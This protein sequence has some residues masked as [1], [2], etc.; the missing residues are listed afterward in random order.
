MLRL[1]VKSTSILGAHVVLGKGYAEGSGT[2]PTPNH[3]ILED[4]LGRGQ[5]GSLGDTQCVCSWQPVEPGTYRR[6]EGSGKEVHE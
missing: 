1:L 6:D 3:Y 2:H 5:V 4:N